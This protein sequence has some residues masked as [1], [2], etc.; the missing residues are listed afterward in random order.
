MKGTIKATATVE[1]AAAAITV[2]PAA[3][4]V[5]AVMAHHPPMTLAASSRGEGRPVQV[6]WE[7]LMRVLDR[8]SIICTFLTDAQGNSGVCIARDL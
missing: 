2:T 6:R 8:Q 1:S 5:T 3:L 7:V 4:I